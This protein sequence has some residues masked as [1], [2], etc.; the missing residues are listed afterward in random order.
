[1]YF[2]AEDINVYAPKKKALRCNFSNTYNVQAKIVNR[3]H[4]IEEKHPLQMSYFDFVRLTSHFP[5][6]YQNMKSHRAIL[7][8]LY[9]KCTCSCIKY[10]DALDA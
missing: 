5:A 4:V 7:N 6:P 1:M 3:M 10:Y 8:N 9:T 2:F